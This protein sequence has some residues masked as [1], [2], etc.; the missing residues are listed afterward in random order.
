MFRLAQMRLHARTSPMTKT[1]RP[2]HDGWRVMTRAPFI[3]NRARDAIKHIHSLKI[4]QHSSFWPAHLGSLLQSLKL[5]DSFAMVVYLKAKANSRH[6][7][8]SQDYAINVSADGALLI[9]MATKNLN[10]LFVL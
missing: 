3:S 10:P 2:N 1:A 4:C 5:L 9:S 6:T 7:H 8:W